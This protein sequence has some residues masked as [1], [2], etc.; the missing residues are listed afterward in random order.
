ML[1][2]QNSCCFVSKVTEIQPILGADLIEQIKVEGWICVSQKGKYSVGDILIV[3]ITDAVI[4]LELSESLNVTSYL[5]K[6]R[7][8]TVK[9]KGV[10][11]ECLLI[12]LEKVSEKYRK[13][14]ADVGELLGIFKYEP[15]AKQLTLSSGKKFRYIDNTNFYKYQKFP[16]IKNSLD[17]F[18]EQDEVEI[19]RKIHG[20]NSRFS[21]IKKSK[22]S[23][24][25]KIKRLLRINRIW[26]DYDYVYGSHNVEKG[27]G[28][29][30]FYSTDVWRTVAETNNIRENLWKFVIEN[31]TPE[32]LGSGIII[33][34]EVY[35]KGIQK[36]YEYGLKTIEIAVF[37]ISINGKYLPYVNSY[38]I[39]KE[40]GLKTVDSLY[41]GNWSKEVQDKFTFNNF[42]EGTKI[43]HEGIVI[44]SIFGDRG[45]VAKCIN[46]EY[47][48][49]AEKKNVGDGH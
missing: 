10:Y 20:S 48:I 30:G 47:L 39:A 49:Y 28:V 29:Q 31:Y 6:G 22:I 34:G 37:D 42:I 23:F 27:S 4:P 1:I 5:R 11:S 45:K 19:S 18:T 21:V 43:P 12:P 8:R 3:A 41:V 44:K 24:F 2:N 36:N 17:M 7:V 25:A 46:P 32:Q 13:E 26:D 9:L 33:Y 35:G 16:N 14:G 38:R 40:L 15:P